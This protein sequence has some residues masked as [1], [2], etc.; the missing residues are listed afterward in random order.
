MLFLLILAR[1]PHHIAQ[2]KMARKDVK[3]KSDYHRR[4]HMN[5]IAD[6]LKAQRFSYQNRL[7]NKG[8]LNLATGVLKGLSRGVFNWL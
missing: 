7:H 8:Q 4:R 6:L 1:K 5:I 3:E 2:R